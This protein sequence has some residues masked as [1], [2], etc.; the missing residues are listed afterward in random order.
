MVYS[1]IHKNYDEKIVM[2]SNKPQKPVFYNVACI[3]AA[4]GT[5]VGLMIFQ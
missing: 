3:V 5:R 4:M 2:R 1:K